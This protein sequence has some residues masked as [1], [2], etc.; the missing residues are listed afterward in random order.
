MTQEQA[1][2]ILKSGENVFLTGSAGTGKTYVL[3]EYIKYLKERKVH[4]AVTASTGIAATHIGGQTIHSWSG[5]GVKSALTRRDI[6]NMA[7]KKY[8]REHLE[9]VKVLI[10]DEISMLHKKQLHMIDEVLKFFKSPFKAFGGVQIVFSGDFFQLPPVTRNDEKNTEKFAFMSPAWV[11][12]NLAICYLTQQYRQSDSSLNNILNEIRTGRVSQNA[13]NLLKQTASN[14]LE[15]EDLTQLYTHNVDVDSVNNKR[16]EELDAKSREFTAKTKGNKN[17]LP[18]LI[19]SVLAPEKLK[20]KIGAK[21]MFVK[22]LPDKGVV[23]GSLGTVIG[24]NEEEENEAVQV[25]LLDGKS[26][27]AYEEKWSFDN[28]TG[29]SLASF[30]QLPLRLAWAIT[31]HKSQGMTLDAAQIDLSKTFETGQGYVAISRLK[32]MKGLCVK[33]LNE[34]ALKVDGLALK[35]DKRFK[36]LSAEAEI[37]FPLS[38]LQERFD[39]FIKMC[40]GL[41]NPD[42]IKK[43]K[44]KK[45]DKANKK[46]THEKTLDL[47]KL[48]LSIAEMANERG[49]T[50]GT[51][52]GHLQ[53]INDE[54][55]DVELY[56]YRPPSKEINKVKKAI[57]SIKGNPKAYAKA[58]NADNT[59]KHGAV[60]NYLKGGMSYEQINLCML[61]VDDV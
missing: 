2:A 34:M 22:N 37:Q 21:V 42:E 19:K 1:I 49:L 54:F 13:V 25:K 39:P 57:L 26:V 52:I 58:L 10:I 56:M 53:K 6:T 5:I 16:L 31:V 45:A 36:E 38:E 43:H 4:V 12:A 50:N 33:G 24:F 55:K 17:L 18:T 32:N 8:L 46:P 35:A 59:L 7:D 60:Y 14:K 29:S 20:L 51:I 61:F 28:E 47:V 30:Y 41:T 9:D 23:N 27:M 11:S 3:N 15:K 44:K 40:G 48:G